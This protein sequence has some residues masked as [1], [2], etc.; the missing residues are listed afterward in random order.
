MEQ[1]G[2]KQTQTL[3]WVKVKQ[4]PFEKLKQAILAE[5]RKSNF[6]TADLEK[7]FTQFDLHTMLAFGMGRLFRQAHELALIGVRGKAYAKLKNKSQ[8]SVLFGVNAKHSKKPDELQDRLEIMFPTG[9]K[10]EMFARREKLN[11]TCTGLEC[12]SSL[13]EDMADSLARLAKL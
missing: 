10:L 13:G 8:R 9:N 7:C 4:D 5:V 6:K 1:W 3:P 12:P 2:F 11:W